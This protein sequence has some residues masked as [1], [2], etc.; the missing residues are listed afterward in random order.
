MSAFIAAARGS[1]LRSFSYSYMICI[2]CLQVKSLP[3]SISALTALTS[4]HVTQELD[5]GT[6]GVMLPSSITALQA[7]SAVHVTCIIEHL[8]VLAGMKGLDNVTVQVE[9]LPDD[10]AL[11]LLQDALLHVEHVR[12]TD[13]CYHT[14][15]MQHGIIVARQ[16]FDGDE[17][18][19]VS[20]EF[21]D[22]Y[23]EDWNDLDDVTNR[24]MVS[25]F[26]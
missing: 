5:L 19:P 24:H 10:S 17:S 18:E 14:M 16:D 3:A 11:E 12:L 6:E 13:V 15:V 1:D 22:D 26:P 2:H 4:L 9:E 25:H 23:G 7:L 8:A 20:E 21:S